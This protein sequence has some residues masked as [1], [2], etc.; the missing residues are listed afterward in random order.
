MDGY[1]YMTDLTGASTRRTRRASSPQRGLPGL[2][3][4]RARRVSRPVPWRLQGP[5]G[6]GR[7]RDDHRGLRARGGVR[8]DDELRIHVRATNVRGAPLPRVRRRAHRP[9]GSRSRQLDRARLRERGHAAPHAHAHLARRGDRRSRGRADPRHLPAAA[10]A[11]RVVVFSLSSS[12][13][14]GGKVTSCRLRPDADDL[15]LRALAVSPMLAVE[16]P[17]SPW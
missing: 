15:L 4:D 12:G 10:S 8:F 16:D 17:P 11:G 13:G 9:A 1:R 5:R 7:R 6:A 2:V 3:R 14:A